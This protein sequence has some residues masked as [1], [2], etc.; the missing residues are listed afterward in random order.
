[1]A[2]LAP[3]QR[4]RSG[5]LRSA[6]LPQPLLHSNGATY[7]AAVRCVVVCAF[8]A[9]R[10]GVRDGGTAL[11]AAGTLVAGHCHLGAARGAAPETGGAGIQGCRW[12]TLEFAR[13]HRPARRQD[14]EVRWHTVPRRHAE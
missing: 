1:M 13:G 14:H 10:P 12:W 5:S 6:I 7:E 8:A 3:W 11:T 9:G 4:A 2:C